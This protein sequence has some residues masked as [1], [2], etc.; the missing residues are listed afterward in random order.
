MRPSPQ[1][2]S[3][4]TLIELLVVIAII[5]ILIGLL[6]PAVQKVREAAARTQCQNNLKQIGLAAMNYESANGFLPPGQLGAIP[7]QSTGGVFDAQCFGSLVLLL[8]YIEQGTIFNQLQTKISLNDLGDPTVPAGSGRG[9]WN[10][11][12]DWS[13]GWTKIKSFRCPSDDVSSATQ[14]INGAAILLE[15]DPTAGPTNAVT[16]GWFVGGNQYDLGMTNYTGVAGAL[17][18][19][20][21]VSTSDAASGPGANLAMY[22]GLMTNRSKVTIASV[23]DGTSNTLMFGEGLGGQIPGTYT[24]PSGSTFTVTQ[25]DYVWSWMGVGSLGTKFGLAPGGGA[26]PGNNGANL[27]GGVNYFSSRHTGLVQ[28]CFGDGSVHAVHPG[29]TGVRNPTA[30]G[31]DWYVLQAMAGKGDGQVINPTQLSN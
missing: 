20:S 16:F 13:L 26:N 17:G 19:A 22:E 12:P 10:R 2:S 9:W 14:A 27:A 15:P 8:P 29:N 28:F 18:K 24:Q 23:S 31:S 3:A 6:L 7:G 25:R 4:F 1:R 30:A 11:N 5:A 21:E